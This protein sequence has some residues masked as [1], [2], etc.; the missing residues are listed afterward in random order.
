MERPGAPVRAKARYV[1]N[2][3]G[4]NMESRENDKRGASELD[5]LACLSDRS[6]IMCPDERGVYTGTEPHEL[7][8]QVFPVVRP[9]STRTTSKHD[10]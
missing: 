4:G 5:I 10:E 2:Q 1:D 3:S 8:D 9:R 6:R 7:T